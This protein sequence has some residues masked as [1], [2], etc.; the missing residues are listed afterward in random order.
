MAVTVFGYGLRFAEGSPI[1]SVKFDNASS[2]PAM[3]RGG[4][5]DDGELEVE[6]AIL[7][8]LRKDPRWADEL[9][10]AGGIT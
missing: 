5:I 2:Q 3:D 6:N 1:S 10:D 9:A 7:A 4:A 8:V